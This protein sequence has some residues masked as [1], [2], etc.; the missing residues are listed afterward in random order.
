ME[1]R[2]KCEQII[3]IFNG[4]TI[5]GAKDPLLVK[6]ADGGPK[7][8][9]LFK[10]PDPNA[11]AWREVSAEGIPVTYDPSMQQNGVSVNVGTPIGMP[12]SRFGAPQVGGYPVAGSQWIPGYMMTQ[13]ITQVDDQVSSKDVI[14]KRISLHLPNI[15]QYS[16]S[17]LQY[18]QMAAGPQLGVTSYK[19]DAVNQVQPRGIS[20]M[21]SGET[22]V[23]YGTM[24]P[25]L[26]TLQIG[27]SVSA[28]WRPI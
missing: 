14:T 12:Y 24:M 26:A 4:N 5:P 2:E 20:M 7:K 9:N 1:S 16:S 13:P 3:Q 21:V 28:Y 27:N 6:F 18:M 10:T 17:A 19:P 23:P 15:Y 25:Q 22:A 11:R 8:K